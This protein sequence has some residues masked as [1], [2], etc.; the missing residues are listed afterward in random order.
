M[1]IDMRKISFVVLS[2]LLLFGCGKESFTPEVDQTNRVEGTEY[3]DFSTG[4]DANFGV[5]FGTE[6][7]A[8]ALLEVYTVDP[9][10]NSNAR[11]VFKSFLDVKGQFTGKIFLAS[12]VNEVWL[13]AISTD[14]ESTAKVSV[15]GETISFSEQQSKTVEGLKVELPVTQTNY[16]FLAFEDWLQNG[17]FDLNDVVVVHRRDITFGNQNKLQT[18][19]DYFRNVHTGTAFVDAFCFEHST[20]YLEE[21]GAN[22]KTTVYYT[23]DRRAIENI[24]A[25]NVIW[26]EFKVPETYLS[27][28]TRK[29]DPAGSLRKT[30]IL[31]DNAR[32]AVG[33]TYRIQREMNGISDKQTFEE[34]YESMN[35]LNPFIISH[36]DA[37]E[38]RYDEVHIAGDKNLMT[39]RAKNNNGWA[40]FFVVTTDHGNKQFPYG[41]RI[42]EETTW[43]LVTEGNRIDTEYPNFQ[44]WVNTSL[45]TPSNKSYNLWYKDK[46]D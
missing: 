21:G 45:S 22:V 35:Q 36:Y 25:E 26:R 5:N 6:I 38:K 46:K 8:G 2:S 31:M 20:K 37:N 17:D 15:Q 40:D 1:N 33:R 9:S 42:T 11:P 44:N 13:R 23:D 28:K 34:N 43:S 10:K 14:T 16:E 39:E 30:Y 3:F 29:G 12:W 24:D 19:T 4:E 7:G 32:A 18:V 41:L 27:T